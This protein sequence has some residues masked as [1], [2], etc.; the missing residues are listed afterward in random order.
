VF[1]QGVDLY[2]LD[3]CVDLVSELKKIYPQIG[4]LFALAEIGETTYFEETIHR[5]RKKTIADNFFFM[6]GQKEL[7]PLFK[8]CDLMVRPTY[9]DGYGISIAE[10]LYFH[11]PAVA[12]DVG[13]R[14]EGT[15]LF[16][17]RDFDDFLCKVKNILVNPKKSPYNFA[18]Q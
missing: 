15:I 14:P 6:T 12:S 2:G 11:C 9:S 17:N 4:L 16:R 8:K 10:A 5:I 7:W 18:R 13:G 3:L 1:Y